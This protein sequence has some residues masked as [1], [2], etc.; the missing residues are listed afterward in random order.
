L[1]CSAQGSISRLNSEFK[2]AK[3]LFGF[4]E[5]VHDELLTESDKAMTVAVAS[6]SNAGAISNASV[7]AMGRQQQ[8]N[9][10]SGHGGGSG[11][12]GPPPA[13]Q[14]DV[15]QGAG[16]RDPGMCYSERDNGQGGNFCR[17]THSK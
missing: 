17:S 8:R 1:G 10:R 3:T 16:G 6:A 13:A 15:A 11:L 9:G 7:V 4:G 12:M 2:K 5:A 14:D